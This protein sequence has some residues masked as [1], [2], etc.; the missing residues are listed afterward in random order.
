M[1]TSSFRIF[2]ATNPADLAAWLD[3]WQAW[4]EREVFANPYYT[5]LYASAHARA[6]CAAWQC[7]SLNVMYPFVLRDLTGEP[8]WDKSLGPAFD[9]TSVYG[10]SGP[11]AWGEERQGNA[12]SQFWLDFDAWAIQQNIVAEFVRFTLFERMLLPYPGEKRAVADHLVRTLAPSEEALWM[13]FEHKVRKNVNKAIRSG[14]EIEVDT[15]GERLGAFL[16]IYEHTMKRRAAL[17]EYYFGREFFERLHANLP[18]EFVYMHA[19]QGGRIVSTELVLV[20]RTNVYSFL[21]GTREEAFAVRPN[22]LL[23]VEIMKWAK[24]QGKQH[25]VLGGGY[26]KGDGIYRYKESFAPA[27]QVP[28][29][30]GGRIFR[31]EIYDALVSRKAA[32]SGAVG[33]QWSPRPGFFPAYRS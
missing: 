1:P 16:E 9:I 29:Y 2:D 27:G 21:G 33:Q 17:D 28:Y 7:G 22:D 18:T 8:Y 14:V 6:L 10:Y 13:E 12:A 4:P 31:Q 23:K 15:R 11:Y 32:L 25:F 20:S 5:S 30:L 19:Y 26:Q 24:S 3:S